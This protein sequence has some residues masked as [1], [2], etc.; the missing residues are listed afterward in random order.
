MVT[1]SKPKSRPLLPTPHPSSP[2]SKN[3]ISE[4]F[5]IL[6]GKWENHSRA[7]SGFH[8][9]TRAAHGGQ[10]LAGSLQHSAP[11][12][13]GCPGKLRAP[14]TLSAGEGLLRNQ[15]VRD[16][17]SQV[18]DRKGNPWRSLSL[19]GYP[20]KLQANQSSFFP[21]HETQLL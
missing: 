15:H 11:E 21:N 5:P 3:E 16:A 2:D 8:T 6:S 13:W 10:Q 1:F 9:D 14:H 12:A 19:D 17:A 20:S 18:E 7:C 4:D